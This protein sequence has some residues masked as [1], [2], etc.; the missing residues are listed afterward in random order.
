MD[1]QWDGKQ[2]YIVLHSKLKNTIRKRKTL[3]KKHK[4]KEIAEEK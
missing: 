1:K 3:I 4:K 2:K